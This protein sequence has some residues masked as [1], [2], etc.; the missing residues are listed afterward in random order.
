MDES[1]VIEEAVVGLL[2]GPA[3]EKLCLQH[4]L[5]LM[6]TAEIAK[7]LKGTIAE[8][9]KLR[10]GESFRFAPSSLQSTVQV[11]HEMLTKISQGTCPELQI[12][13]ATPLVRQVFAK[14]GFF[15]RI[16]GPVGRPQIVAEAAMAQ[17]ATLVVAEQCEQQDV[18]TVRTF[19]WLV[20]PSAV[21]DVDNA[22]SKFEASGADTSK[23]R[24]VVR[25]AG[26]AASS[27][28]AKKRKKA[29]DAA[30]LAAEAA[31]D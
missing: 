29:D 11:V 15:L 13:S 31:F 30:R 10:N 9:S 18:D 6:P 14:F 3:A 7:D 17:I 12:A 25:P 24:A 28:A 1:W 19:K 5:Q 27:Q 26:G 23:V 2:C 20:A 21:S 4:M 8:I 16:D 22:L